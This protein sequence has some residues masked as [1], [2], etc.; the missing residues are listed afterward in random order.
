MSFTKGIFSSLTLFAKIDAAKIGKDEFFDPDM[1]IL[2]LNSFLHL[3]IS[4]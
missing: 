2:P 1:E 4:F 3:I